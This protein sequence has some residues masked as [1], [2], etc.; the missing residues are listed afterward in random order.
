MNII[1]IA[2][3]GLGLGVVQ[4]GTC[5][6]DIHVAPVVQ[7]NAGKVRGL[8]EKVNGSDLFYFNGIRY[9]L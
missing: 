8:V 3:L 2:V 5:D 4:S 6:S 7:L 1:W 9:G